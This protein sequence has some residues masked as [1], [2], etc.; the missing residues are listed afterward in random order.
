MGT[1]GSDTER[2]RMPLL[3]AGRGAV[4]MAMFGA[5]WLGVG[6]GAPG[7]FNGATGPLFGFAEM[8]LLG[9]SVD[10][11]RSG[12]APGKRFPLP[13]EELAGEENPVPTS[14]TKSVF[15]GPGTSAPQTKTHSLTP[16]MKACR[17]G[18]GRHSPANADFDVL[19]ENL[20]AGGQSDDD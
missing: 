15:G 11:V 5:G 20:R 2:A 18:P 1:S 4:V 10:L 12:R 16:A 3:G 17:G 7:A 14:P 13:A 19:C 9:C 6:L 8:V